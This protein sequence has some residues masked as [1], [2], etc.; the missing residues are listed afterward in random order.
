MIVCAS[1]GREN[2]DDARFCAACGKE[3][4]A[5]TPA[6]EVRKTVTVLF[7]DV[8]GSTALGERTDPEALR[9]TM[10]RW[11][12]EAR[13]VL[14]RH[15][16]TVEKVIGDAV[17]AV[18]GVPQ[19][20]EDDALRAVR[21]AAELQEALQRSD[22]DARIGVN[23]GEVVAAAGDETLV[24]GDA[25]NVAAR[26]E[27]AARTTE[28]LIGQ[29]TERLVRDAAE[30]EPV[31]PLALK[32]KAA[33]VRAFRLVAVRPGAEGRARRLD[34]PLVGRARELERLSGAF[35]DAVRA[36]GCHLFTLLGPAGVGKSRLVEEL[37]R[38]S[39]GR[40]TIL[41]GRCLSYGDGITFW[42]VVEAIPGAAEVVA[43]DLPAAEIF[44]ALR[45][46]VEAR[47]RERPVVL[48]FDDVHWGEPTFLDL[49]E[50]VADWSRD[51]PI[52]LV[53]I[54]RPELLDV[55]PGWGGGKLN[56]TTV[57]L[58]PL[59]DLAA[60]ELVRA[61]VELDADAA[62]RVV[63]AAEGNPLFVEEMAALA[64]EGGDLTAPPTIQ[65][66][67]QAR[68]DRLAGGERTVLEAAAV[69]GKQF[70]ASAVAELVRDRSPLDAE[71]QLLALVRKDLVRP[72]ATS[73]GDD[74][75]N[76][77]HQLIRD[78]AYGGVAKADRAE[79]HERFAS[80]VERRKN[81]GG[82][83]DEILGHHLEQAYRYRVELGRDDERSQALRGRAARVLAAAGRRANLRSDAPAAATLLR[84]APGP[85]PPEEGER[86]E[87]LPPLAGA[88]MQSGGDLEAVG[89]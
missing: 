44:A 47:A 34:A 77:R 65:A 14:E 52:L 29:A 73:A 40:A 37:L 50:H 84:R 13:T 57:L 32:G 63:A 89:Q 64:R 19:A 68:L 5:A 67:L 78:V 81:G 61:L 79:L 86:L 33:P 31:E 1:C 87:L 58:E 30:S 53:C 28:I 59:D 83:F 38:A 72:D 10:R 76:F 36:N 82:E 66:L 26:L 8:V 41:R 12:D 56:A 23:T 25:V 24:T 46:L 11:F 9:R 2:P 51:A 45:K 15:G 6:R 22:V 17:M 88:V 20:H 21:A 42:P 35:D 43:Q 16:G 27:Q 70:H 7:A 71:S 49:V 62:R 39:S 74:A 54:A 75:F 18:F 85:P 69:E 60:L 80:W 48:V 4:A 55:R 3:L